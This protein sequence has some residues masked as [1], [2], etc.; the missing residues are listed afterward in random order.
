ML[1]RGAYES[2]RTTELYDPRGGD[3]SL[4]EVELIRI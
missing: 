4:D 3:V 1:F 2:S